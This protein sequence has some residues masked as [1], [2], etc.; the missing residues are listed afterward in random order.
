MDLAAL[1]Q[2]SEAQLTLV[3]PQGGYVA[4]NRVRGVRAAEE[5]KATHVMFLDSDMLFP[6]DSLNKLLARNCDIVG[7]G[8]RRRSEPHDMMPPHEP[9]AGLVEV[10]W[11]PAGCSLVRMHVFDECGIHPFQ[12][13]PLANG[14]LLSEDQYFCVVARKKG[15][16]VWL[17]RDLTQ[18]VSHIGAQVL[19]A[20]YGTKST[21]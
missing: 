13:V 8:Y 19:R 20:S 3:N 11:L 18:D 15:Y 7:A 1:C 12:T 6:P 16:S 17:D 21:T 10:P 2:A 4:H 14:N 9:G 5:Y